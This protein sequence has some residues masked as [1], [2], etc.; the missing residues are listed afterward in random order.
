MGSFGFLCCSP[1]TGH[2]AAH[3]GGLIWFETLMTPEL[4]APQT[5]VGFQVE[6][7]SA[8]TA[9]TETWSKWKVIHMIPEMGRKRQ[10]GKQVCKQCTLKGIGR[11]FIYT[12]GSRAAQ[13]HLKTAL[14]MREKP[15]TQ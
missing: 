14:E 11:E 15:Q 3:S 13:L 12:S 10:K 9:Q 6:I 2:W 4:M 1:V 5:H 7:K 8:E